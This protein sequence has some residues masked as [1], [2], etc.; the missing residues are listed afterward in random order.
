MELGQVLDLGM[1]HEKLIAEILWICDE[2]GLRAFYWP[3]S[4][5]VSRKGWPDLA[6]N[7]QNGWIF[8]ECKTTFGR[9]SREQRDIGYCLTIAGFDYAVWRPADLHSG[10]IRATLRLI[11]GNRAK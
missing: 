1:T 9:I 4:R 6:V 3:D 10:L 11:A 7:G 8:R 5:K 2:Y